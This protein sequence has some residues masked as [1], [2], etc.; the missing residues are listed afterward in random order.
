MTDKRKYEAD[1]ER[2]RRK[3]KALG[4]LLIVV[5]GVKGDGFSA[6]MHP[7]LAKAIPGMLRSVADEI[8]ASMKKA[9]KN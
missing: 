4:V 7:D 2:V 9:D 5:H 1:C 3:Q 6:S 8:E